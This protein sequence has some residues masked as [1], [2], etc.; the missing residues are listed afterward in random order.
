VIESNP[1]PGAAVDP[2]S[3]VTITVSSGPQQA[4]VPD[5]RGQT[6]EQ[7]ITLLEAAGLTAQV[8]EVP[9]TDPAADNLVSTQNPAP[10]AR[11]PRGAQVSIVVGRSVVPE[12]TET[13]TTGEG[14]G[15][16]G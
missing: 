14:E 6:Q 16:D 9:V 15:G 10:Q 12:T 11:A 2:G 4:T 13:G 1:G 3:T 7:A 8:E 5:V